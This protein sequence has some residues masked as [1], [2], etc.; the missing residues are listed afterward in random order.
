MTIKDS[1]KWVKTILTNCWILMMKSY[2]KKTCWK[3][4]QGRGVEEEN[5]ENADKFAH[6]FLFNFLHVNFFY[7]Q[8]FVLKIA[9]RN[10]NPAGST[11]SGSNRLRP[12]SN[13]TLPFTSDVRCRFK[14]L[15]ENSYEKLLY[16]IIVFYG[17]REKSRA[18]EILW[19]SWVKMPYFSPV[20]RIRFVL[21]VGWKVF[22]GIK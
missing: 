12:I 7:R 5:R 21:I 9:Q 16:W 14:S 15:C 13:S 10:F 11:C 6:K 20:V 1:P 8:K 22:F 19:Q 4:R 17:P 2:R 18:G 3:Q